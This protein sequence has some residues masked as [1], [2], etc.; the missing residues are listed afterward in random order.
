MSHE[1]TVEDSEILHEAP[2]LA[3]RRDTVSMPGGRSAKREII[4]HFGAVAVVAMRKSGEIAMVRQ[5]RHSVQQRL[6][7]L[8]AGLLD[9]ADESALCCAQRE[10]QEE[11]G[12]SAGRWE[13]LTD[14]VSSP[15]FCEE[16]IRIFIARDLQEVPQPEAV[17]EEADMT[18]RWIAV[19]QAARAVMRGEIVNSI[20]VSGIMA[21]YYATENDTAL[22]SV[23]TPFSLRPTRL[24]A[25]RA[26][27]WGEGDLKRV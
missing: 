20:A 15:G 7:E 11:A 4:E 18:L 10:L 9:V 24:A 12:L 21:A 26:A 5:Y 1:F 17:D 22:R 23:D 27:Q 16:A 2:I 14:V 6:W 19:D 3:L 25:R 13:L 8:P